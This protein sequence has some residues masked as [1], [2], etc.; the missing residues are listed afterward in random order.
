[1]TRKQLSWRFSHRLR[2][3]DMAFIMKIPFPFVEISIFA[4]TVLK[5]KNEPGRKTRGTR[6]CP[7]DLQTYQFP[8]RFLGVE[9]LWTFLV[10][11]PGE[12]EGER[13]TYWRL[14]GRSPG[15]FQLS[16]GFIS[17]LIYA[18]GK[19]AS[20]TITCLP[21]R[22]NYEIIY[23]AMPDSGL[24]SR[25]QLPRRS[26]RNGQVPLLPLL[27]PFLSSS[28]SSSSSSCRQTR[29]LRKVLYVDYSIP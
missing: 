5:D 13:D 10:S 17:R 19:A 1:M 18:D 28:P 20:L 11:A 4:T 2:M 3:R 27:S 26:I 23:L 22:S 8:F 12:I 9:G 29:S 7:F 16:R 6:L 14:R 25:S 15:W 24:L 21:E